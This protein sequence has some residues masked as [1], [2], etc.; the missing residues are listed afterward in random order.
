[1]RGLADSRN[2]LMRFTFKDRLPIITVRVGVS[3]AREEWLAGKLE[4]FEL[5]VNFREGFMELTP[6]P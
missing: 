1:M 4:H 2:G 5:T 3:A 6:L